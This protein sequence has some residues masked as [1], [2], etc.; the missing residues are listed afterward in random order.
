MTAPVELIIS[1]RLYYPKERTD[2]EKKYWNHLQELV[3]D[4]LDNKDLR[5]MSW[6]VHKI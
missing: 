1:V 3:D 2:Y 6:K 4:T 5:E